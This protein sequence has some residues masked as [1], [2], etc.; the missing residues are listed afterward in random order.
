MF[1]LKD[2]IIVSTTYSFTNS[3]LFEVSN[4]I[5]KFYWVSI[6]FKN[7]CPNDQINYFSGLKS[8]EY[9]KHMSVFYTI[10]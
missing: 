1:I 9:M 3:D 2:D 5:R 7:N 4:Q 6:F 10:T 8:S